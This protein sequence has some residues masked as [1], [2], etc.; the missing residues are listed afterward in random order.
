MGSVISKTS[1]LCQH[2]VHLF[3]F[4]AYFI[5]AFAF[6]TIGMQPVK[7]PSTVYATETE[8]ATGTLTIPNINL[9][10]PVKPINLNGNDLDV[11]EQI[12]GSYSV[13]NNKTLIVGHSSTVFNN[14]HQ[15]AIDD[16]IEY[17]AK[18]YRITKIEEKSKTA[19]SMKEILKPEE[20]DTL[21]LMTC[22]GEQIDG[23]NGDHTHRLII[24]ATKSL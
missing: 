8:N 4:C 22:S 20:T 7:D 2:K 23:S 3:V 19:I 15:L 16:T 1:F 21:V 14:L 5:A 18:S 10:T 12:A 6:L 13:H 11:P 24:T 17:A 9:N